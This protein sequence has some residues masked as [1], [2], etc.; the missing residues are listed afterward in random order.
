[1]EKSNCYFMTNVGGVNL[2]PELIITPLEYMKQYVELFLET[3]KYFP[4]T[5][6][7]L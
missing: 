3:E 2:L 7:Y 1:M 6:Y 5:A 4:L